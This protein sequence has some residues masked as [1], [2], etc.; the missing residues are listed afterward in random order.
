MPTAAMA[1][2][3]LLVGFM[4]P[5]GVGS[6]ALDESAGFLVEVSI[7]H[8]SYDDRCRFLPLVDG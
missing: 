4:V 8:W 3:L 6:E 7:G 5:P 2:S 1:E